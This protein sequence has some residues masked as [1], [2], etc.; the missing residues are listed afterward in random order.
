[1]T[2]GGQLL[3][4]RNSFTLSPTGSYTRVKTKVT[5]LSAT[6]LTNVRYWIGTQDDWVGIA[7]NPAKTKGTISG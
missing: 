2:I 5:N 4:V 3:Q 6:P 7:D 1:M